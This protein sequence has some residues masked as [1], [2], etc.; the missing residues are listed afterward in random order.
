MYYTPTPLLMRFSIFLW[1]IVFCSL[2]KFV[3]AGTGFTDHGSCL[4]KLGPDFV[5]Q[6]N[7]EPHHCSSLHSLG[8]ARGSPSFIPYIVFPQPKS[9]SRGKH[10]N[11]HLATFSPFPT[12]SINFYTCIIT[13]NFLFKL[14]CPPFGHIY[15]IAHILQVHIHMRIH[16]DKLL[17]RFIIYN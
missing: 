5:Q 15:H 3:M 16:I 12:S 10:K 6:M 7:L 8:G 17:Q 1:G 2:K 9:G 14:E 13:H 11:K 4:S